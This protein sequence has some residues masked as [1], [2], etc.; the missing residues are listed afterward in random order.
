MPLKS[1]FE[2]IWHITPHCTCRHPAERD[3]LRSA[4]HPPGL[5][6]WAHSLNCELARFGLPRVSITSIWVD[7]TPQCW[8]GKANG[9]WRKPSC[10]LADLLVVAWDDRRRRTGTALLVQSKKGRSISRISVS[11]ASTKK[12]LHLLGAAPRF[13]LSGQTS[14][15]TGYSPQPMN[16]NVNCEFQLDSYKGIRLQHCT[17]LQIKD[18][19]AKRWPT[20]SS[21]W[22]TLWPPSAHHEPYTEAIIGMVI[23]FPSALGKPFVKNSKRDEWDR[24]VSLLIN[25]TISGITGT[26]HGARQHTVYHYDIG[27]FSHGGFNEIIENEPPSSNDPRGIS[28]VFITPDHNG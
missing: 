13:L 21:S 15:R 7:H 26:A 8:Y 12:E 10:E 19:E 11:N 18:Q 23:K 28:T 5:W 2:H 14:A 22:Q 4:H 24:L 9:K 3:Y 17:F 16:P 6:I 20:Q 25:E 27:N 1:A